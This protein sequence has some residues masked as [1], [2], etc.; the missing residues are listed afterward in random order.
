MY[1]LINRLSIHQTRHHFQ[2]GAGRR[3]MGC[4]GR[5]VKKTFRWVSE[6]RVNG[7]VT[8]QLFREHL[9]NIFQCG[10]LKGPSLSS[11]SWYNFLRYLHGTSR[12]FLYIRA[13]FLLKLRGLTLL[14]FWMLNLP[15]SFT[16]WFSW[17]FSLLLAFSF[18]TSTC[19]HLVICL[20]IQS[21]KILQSYQNSLTRRFIF[22]FFLV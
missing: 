19:F 14:I 10:F 7:A 18:F 22:H 21:F 20:C 12:Y 8:W 5:N 11:G 2:V 1:L 13:L 16:T 15:I 9:W 17:L 3:A 6:A 4:R